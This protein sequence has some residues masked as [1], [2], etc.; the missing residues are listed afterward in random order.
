MKIVLDTNVLISGTFWTGDSFKILNKIDKEEIELI[1][2]EDLIKEYE[3]IINSDE[4]IEKITDKKLILN[5]V[6]QKVINNSVIVEPKQK[7]NV[8]KDD[9]KDNKII[10]A[11]IEGK[12]DYI[13][14]QDKHLLKLKSYQGIKIISPE[15][16]LEILSSRGR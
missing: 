15:E 3:K 4:I 12:A 5:K 14:S 2:S 10:E 1:I 7:F 16:F 8:V 6:V 11:A 13:I 9:A